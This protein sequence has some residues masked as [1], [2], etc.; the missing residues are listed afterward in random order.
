MKKKKGMMKRSL[1]MILL[2]IVLLVGVA[3]LLVACSPRFGATVKGA[4]LERLEQ[5][6]HYRGGVFSNQEETTI[7]DSYGAWINAMVERFRGGAVSYPT[8]PLPMRVMDEGFFAKR[9]NEGLSV[10][11]LGHSTAL[12]EIEGHRILTDPVFSERI[13]PISFLGPKRFPGGLPITPEELPELDVVL[14]S[15]DHYDHLD[16][17]SILA[18]K[19][20]T[21]TFV[22]PLGV[23]SHL[24]KW[25]VA[26]DKIIELDWWEEH[27]LGSLTLAATPSQHFSGR[28]LLD[29]NKTLWASWAIL[30]ANHRVFFGGD[31]GFFSGFRA[32]GEK[33]GPFD[34]TMLESG[35]YSQ[36]WPDIHMMP[37]E[38]VQAHLDLGG[39][40]LLPIHWAR[41]NLSLHSWT[42]PIERLLQEAEVRGVRVATPEMG[43][44]VAARS[45]LP[46]ETWWRSGSVQAA[47]NLDKALPAA[48]RKV[49]AESQ[50]M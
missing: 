19:D 36:Y 23:G 12:I 41:F 18:L 47:Q 27:E 13:S 17:A 44:T 22:V 35:A 24:R 11:W 10:T 28:G 32:I 48:T 42:E 38:T 7:V 40:V 1:K 49:T 37:E 6:E 5:S 9:S 25:G 2:A 15:H 50:S 16:Y 46:K 21:A 3:V 14:I 29:R 39:R 33:Y 45:P 30:G 34:V 4:W 31:S 43:Q 8:K 26:Q 20:K